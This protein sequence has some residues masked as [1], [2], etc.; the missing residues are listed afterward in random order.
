MTFR[1]KFVQAP[2]FLGSDS[3]SNVV[4][5]KLYTLLKEDLFYGIRIGQKRIKEQKQEFLEP[6]FRSQGYRVYLTVR[7]PVE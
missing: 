7:P 1:T 2:R 6:Q 4:I 3:R 5:W